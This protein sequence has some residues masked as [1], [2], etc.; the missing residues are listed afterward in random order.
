VV[1]GGLAAGCATH[2]DL[3]RMD[4]RVQGQLRDQREQLK[5]VQRELESLRAAMEESGGAPG[6]GGGDRLS[7]LEQRVG[8]LERG[9]LPSGEEWTEGTAPAAPPPGSE[10]AVAT[11]KPPAAEP[12]PP[13][14]PDDGWRQEVAR[15]QA[16][17]GAVNVAERAEYLA[18]LDGVALRDCPRAVPQLNGFAADRKD[19]PLAD[20]AL[21]WAGRCYEATGQQEDAIS[22]FYEVGTRYP[23]GDKA[24]A[25]LWAQANLF[26]AMGNSPDARIIFAKLIRDYPSSDEAG[27]ARR[28]LGEIEN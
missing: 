19:S 3:V 13:K 6:R 12:S 24:P 2:A 1:L 7:W 27:Q 14:V 15:E 23:K 25:A 4:R 20:N 11:A 16:A 5:L 10:T 21:Y 22:K 18:L 28:R 9:T 8:Q 26:L 17:A